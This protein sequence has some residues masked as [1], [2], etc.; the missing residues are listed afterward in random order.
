V[1][2]GRGTTKPFELVG[3]PWID[4]ERF[5]AGLNG[6]GLPGVHFRPAVFEPTF[7]KHAGASCG[8]CQIHIT[9][10]AAFTPVAA[11]VTLIAACHAAGPDRFAW[12]DPPY[13]YEFT[14][15]P[16]DILYGST[17]LREGLAAGRSVADIT[18]EW[19][20]EVRDFLAVREKFLL[21]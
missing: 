9:D 15:L 6:A 16:I 18:R 1:S 7:H 5:G 3:A 8:G 2:E 17:A 20:D 10:R 11:A 21:Y 12:R 14:K 13:E 4:A 19:P